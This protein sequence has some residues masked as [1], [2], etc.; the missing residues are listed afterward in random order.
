MNLRLLIA[1]QAAIR[2]R[3]FYGQLAFDLPS[4]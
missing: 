1:F 4:E 2:N 3:A